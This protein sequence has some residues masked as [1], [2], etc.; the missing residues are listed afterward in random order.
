MKNL[1][2]INLNQS[3]ESNFTLNLKKNNSKKRLILQS[4]RE[5]VTY[6]EN[7]GLKFCDFHLAFDGGPEFQTRKNENPKEVIKNKGR[8]QKGV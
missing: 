7:N 6:L 2:K 3:K 8:N 4:E 5:R 1:I